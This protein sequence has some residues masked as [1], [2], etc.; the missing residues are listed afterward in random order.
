MLA[1]PVVSVPTKARAGEHVGLSGAGFKAGTRVKVVFDRRVVVASTV[2]GPD[3]TFKASMTV[4]PA[5][6]GKHKLQVVGTASSGE[7][8]T[9]AAH[10]VVLSTKAAL[11]VV[12]TPSASLAPPVLLTLSIVAPL[13]TWLALEVLGWR[14]RGS[15]GKR[16]EH[17]ITRSPQVAAA[18]AR[19]RRFTDGSARRLP[20]LHSAHH[21]RW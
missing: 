19:M 9:L 17:R 20:P 4:P 11:P 6:P 2:T 15:T 5:G 7:P 13:S 1:I 18:A 3:G 8:A 16:P 10:V 14:R 12:A 21:S